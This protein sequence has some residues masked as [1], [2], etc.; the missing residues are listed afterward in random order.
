M[1]GTPTRRHHLLT[2]GGPVQET[3]LIERSYRWWALSAVLLV[4]FTSSISSTI[5]STAVPTIVADLHGFSLY[6]WVFTGYILASTVTVP[7][8][9]KL[10]DL[11]GRRPLYL[12]GIAVFVL[13]AILAAAAQ[14]MLWLICARVVSGLGGGAMMALSTASIGDIFSPRERGRWMGVVMGVFGLA[15]IVGPTLGGT[16]TDQIGWRYVFLVPLPLA[17][18]AWLVIGVVMPRVRLRRRIRLDLEGSA[19]MT[20]GLVGV[21]LAVTW[22][23]TSYPWAS[24]Q[25]VVCFAAGAVLLAL[26]VL[27]ERR[28]A[29][30]ILSPVLFANRVFS[31]SVAISFLIVAGMYGSLSFIPLFVQGVV[32]KTAQNSG[33]VLTPMMLSFVA[34]SAIGGQIISRTGRYKLQAIIGMCFAVAG[35]VLFSRLSASSG[36][37]EVIRD[38]IVLG[39][40]IGTTMP[41]FSMT[42]QSAF[43]H[44]L[45]GTVNSGRQL[46][47]NLGG[48]VA[49]PVM[50]AILVNRFSTD[51]VRYAPAAAR[52]QLAGTTISPQ[53]LLTPEAQRAIR[54]HF[55]TLP[56]GH[57][58]YLQFVA[59]VRRSLAN[60]IV[61]IFTVGVGLAAAGLLLTLAFPRIE[62]TSWEPGSQPESIAEEAGTVG[63]L[64]PDQR[65]LVETSRSEA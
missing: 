63:S 14:S 22:G 26:F 45:L 65:R 39:I 56:H 6:G 40:G 18:F 7:I 43:P 31:L 21:L 23:G 36:S 30:P 50:T 46:F 25:I 9:G 20:G 1:T 54:Q 55:S 59:A 16:I 41:I 44:R 15:S 60:G 28:A 2:W 32:G 12:V 42:V 47:S 51:L 37:G 5:V 58:V 13:G 17:A 27:N 24:W 33:V 64:T 19:L 62:L 38:M 11:Y 3:N 49:V 4:M 29:E 10:S 34:G 8:F 35:F 61:D 48:A 57:T 53:S 52:K